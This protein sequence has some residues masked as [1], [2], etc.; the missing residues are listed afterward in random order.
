MY[1]T[2]QLGMHLFGISRASVCLLVREMRE[3]LVQVV[4]PKY[5]RWSQGKRLWTVV[6]LLSRNGVS[7]PQCAG[8]VDGSHIPIIAPSS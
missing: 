2:E 4:I 8:V 3:Q 1:S 6:K 7:D 5:I